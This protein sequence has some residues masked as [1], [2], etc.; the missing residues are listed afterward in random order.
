LDIPASWENKAALVSNTKYETILPIVL[1]K[2]FRYAVSSG[3]NL[4]APTTESSVT[5]PKQING[6]QY[7]YTISNAKTGP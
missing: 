4:A 2:P 5:L 3:S 1:G 6:K 7:R